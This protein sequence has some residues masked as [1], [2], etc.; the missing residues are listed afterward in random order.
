MRRS[1]KPAFTLIELLVVIAILA[2]LA[3][4]LFPVFAQARAK[5]RQAACLSNLKQIGYALQMY[6][7][8]YDGHLPNCCSW[9]RVGTLSD[10][11][12]RCR[13]DGITYATPKD[14][15][16][17]PEQTPPRYIQELLYPYVKS[18]QIWFCPSVGRNLH[19][20]G[21][22]TSP[23]YAY[24]GTTYWWNWYVDPA[25]STD[26]NPFRKRGTIVVSGLVIA[27]IP[28]PAEAFVIQEAPFL[29]P[30]KEPC[31]RLNLRPAHAKGLNVLY[32]DTHARFSKFSGRV[33]AISGMPG[34]CMENWA[35]E[36]EW[37]GFYE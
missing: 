25:L 24:N 22:P 21:D 27:A 35:Y 2:V 8:D 16:L 14:A 28:R 23:T 13:Q 9:A 15:Y 29:N 5:A 11:T 30:V 37:E 32:A 17:G 4:L 1:R 20:L 19:W 6:L 12:G 33:S 34:N 7:Q 10:L 36:H 18:A 3:A 26:P 31:T